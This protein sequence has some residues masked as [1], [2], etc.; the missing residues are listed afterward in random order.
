MPMI[1]D[2]ASPRQRLH[3]LCPSRPKLVLMQVPMIAA[4]PDDEQLCNGLHSLSYVP[5]LR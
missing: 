1:G 3:P 2:G 4:F 5:A